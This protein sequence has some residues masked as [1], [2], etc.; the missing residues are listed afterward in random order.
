MRVLVVLLAALAID[1]RTIPHQQLTRISGDVAGIRLPEL[2]P[3]CGTD[4]EDPATRIRCKGDRGGTPRGLLEGVIFTPAI[5]IYPPQQRQ[6]IYDA[7][8]TG[9]GPGGAARNYTHMAV[10]LG[11]KAG[12]RGYHSIYPPHSCDG[13]FLNTLLREMYD[14]APPII[15]ICFVMNDDDRAVNLPADFDRSLCRLVVPRW[16]SPFADCDLAAVRAA[17]PDALAYW[18]NPA[19][20]VWPKRDSCS[21]TPFQEGRDW[22][23][24]ARRTYGLRGVLVETDIRVLGKDPAAAAHALE[25]ARHAWQDVDAVLFETDIY[26]KFWDG[27]TEAESVAYNDAILRAVPWLRGFTSGG[28]VS[29]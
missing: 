4:G 24:H 13:A 5:N 8:T 21:P 18:E 29:R 1:P 11:C 9:E 16:E 28:T 26:Q 19:G 10:H 2:A 12:E 23:L 20:Q 7:Y 22:F 17:F 6:K 15:P 27:R 3:R 25:Q 14:H